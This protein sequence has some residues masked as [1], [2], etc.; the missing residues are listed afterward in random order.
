MS[1]AIQTIYPS[2]ER[3]SITTVN[4][5]SG[6]SIVDGVTAQGLRTTETGERNCTQTTKKTDRTVS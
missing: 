5:G 4:A 3:R 2:G 6:S 1:L